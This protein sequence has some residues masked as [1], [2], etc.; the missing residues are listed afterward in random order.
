[1]CDASAQDQFDIAV[2]EATTDER[3]KTECLEGI[4]IDPA[5]SGRVDTAETFGGKQSDTPQK[6]SVRGVGPPYP[7]GAIRKGFIRNEQGAKCWY[8]QG[9]VRDEQSYFHKDLL[10]NYGVLTF[11]NPKCMR[12]SSDFGQDVNK[13]MINNIVVRRYSHSDANF[14]T[15]V[16]EMFDGSLSQSR[17]KCIQS[18]TYPG[19]GVA[20]QYLHSGS[21]IAQVVHGSTIQGCS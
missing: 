10:G 11:D 18:R 1:M 19:I 6:L 14:A 7:P 5:K 20:I 15:R 13:R 9:G 12:A 21:S 4:G 8:T 3:A 17:G 16:G 2:C